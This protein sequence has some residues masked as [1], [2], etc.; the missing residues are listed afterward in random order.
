MPTVV[1]FVKAKSIDSNIFTHK[2]Q[3][4]FTYHLIRQILSY[5]FPTFAYT[6]IQCRF[7]SCIW[8]NYSKTIDSRETKR[9]DVAITLFRKSTFFTNS[10]LGKPPIMPS[11]SSSEISMSI[12]RAFIWGIIYFCTIIGSHPIWRKPK[13]MFEVYDSNPFLTVY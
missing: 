13:L 8:R 3:C 2:S 12:I 1:K 5:F 9:Q 6:T 4:F 10:G 7:F 11:P